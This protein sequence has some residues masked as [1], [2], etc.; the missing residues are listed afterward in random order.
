MGKGAAI[1]G[2]NWMVLS[3][4]PKSSKMFFWSF[5][6]FYAHYLTILLSFE[7]SNITLLDLKNFWEPVPELNHCALINFVHYDLISKFFHPL[8]NFGHFL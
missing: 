8:F 6:S 4:N 1:L 3:S 5:L 7:P 2:C